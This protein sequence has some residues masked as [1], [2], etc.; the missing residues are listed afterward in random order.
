ML[1]KTRK[2]AF[3]QFPSK[4]DYSHGYRILAVG[5]EPNLQ[6]RAFGAAARAAYISRGKVQQTCVPGSG[7][8]EQKTTELVE[9]A[10]RK[11]QR[12]EEMERL[13]T[14][15]IVMQTIATRDMAHD[16]Q[17]C[18]YVFVYETMVILVMYK[19]P[20]SQKENARIPAL[21]HMYVCI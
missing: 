12:I 8:L 6:L 9:K 10:K 18:A 19:R 3:Y 14:A 13:R 21:H 20:G 11:I 4:Q 16:L 2:S 17:V 1:H 5:S 15:N 7:H